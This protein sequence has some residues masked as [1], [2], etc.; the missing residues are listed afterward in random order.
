M[1]VKKNVVLPVTWTIQHYFLT[2]IHDYL[3]FYHPAFYSNFL[4]AF[5][6]FILP[7]EDCSSGSRKLVVF[8]QFSQRS[9]FKF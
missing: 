5:S 7:V 2:N 3:H 8:N 6:S 9:F 1:F 4:I